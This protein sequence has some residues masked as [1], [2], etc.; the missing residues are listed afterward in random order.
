MSP[1][2]EVHTCVRSKLSTTQREEEA[3]WR[4]PASTNASTTAPECWHA[5]ISRAEGV[6]RAEG[7]LPDPTVGQ[8]I[9]EQGLIATV[10]GAQDNRGPSA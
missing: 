7:S 6:P 3:T 5:L 1:L 8:L 9:E 10:Y 2:R 4:V